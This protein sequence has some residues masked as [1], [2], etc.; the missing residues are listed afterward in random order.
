MR[1]TF[2]AAR[3]ALVFLTRLPVGNSLSSTADHTWAPAH[4]PLVGLLLGCV[5]AILHSALRRL[6]TLPDATLVIAVSLV[7]TG[8]LHEDGL[9]DTSDALYGASE[10]QRVL[11]ILK[12]SRIGTFGACALVVSIVGRIVLL[13]QLG[14]AAGWAL[15]IVG[16]AARV[17]PVWQMIA[18]PHLGGPSAKSRHVQGA[19]MPQALAATAWFVLASAGLVAFRVVSIGRMAALGGLLVAVT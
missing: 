13:S 15:P 8:A 14:R 4:F 18:L 1:A 6:G 2:R 5:L 7:V 17:A 11:E 19:R 10:R 16:C 9:A 3:A 12:D